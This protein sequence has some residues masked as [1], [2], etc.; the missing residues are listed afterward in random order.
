MSSSVLVV[1]RAHAPEVI[2]HHVPVHFARDGLAKVSSY[3][4]PS[5][6]GTEGALRASLRG[7]AL[8][9]FEVALPVNTSGVVFRELEGGRAREAVALAKQQR[10]RVG[11][12]SAASRGRGAHRH[13]HDDD[14]DDEDDDEDDDDD[15]IENV[16]ELDNLS[17]IERA[18]VVDG[19]F[20]TITTWTHDT[21]YTEHDVL[22]RALEWL[23]VAHA[24][25]AH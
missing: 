13:R 10:K 1:P 4:V 11:S 14:D 2:M 8:D 20:K 3:F 23:A 17:Q 21:P 6:C 9:G 25:H 7:R 16:D 18:W 15:D 5:S 22:P 19:T 24:L 12:K